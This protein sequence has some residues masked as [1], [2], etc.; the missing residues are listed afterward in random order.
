MV[1]ESHSG[2]VHELVAGAAQ[3]RGGGERGRGLRVQVAEVWVRGMGR[4]LL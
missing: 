1:R 4:L 3:Q 2:S